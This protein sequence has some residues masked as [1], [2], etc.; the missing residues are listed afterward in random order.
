[1]EWPLFEWMHMDCLHDLI[2]L[3]T[4]LPQKEDNLRT[5]IVKVIILFMLFC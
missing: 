1:M 4:F 3:A 2:K 5:R